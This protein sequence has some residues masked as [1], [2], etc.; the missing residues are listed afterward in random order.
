M[1][2][3]ATN[4]QFNTITGIEGIL[5]VVV[6][7]FGKKTKSFLTASDFLSEGRKKFKNGA[8]IEVFSSVDGFPRLLAIRLTH[9][10]DAVSG[11][12][13]ITELGIKHDNL[14]DE[15]QVTVLLKTSEISARVIA[16]IQ[17]TRPSF[18]DTLIKNCNPSNGTL[19]LRE[20]TLD[21]K[22]AIPFKDSIDDQSRD[23]PFVIISP[24]TNGT[25]LVD[26][27]KLRSLLYGICEL[28][29][30]PSTSNTYEIAGIIG[31]DNAAWRGA[32]NLIMPRRR[33]SGIALHDTLRLMPDDLNNTQG[34]PE[35]EVFLAI[36]HRTNL[37]LSW[38]HISPEFVRQQTLRREINKT[39]IKLK[40]NKDC[41]DCDY[42]TLLEGADQEI[43]VKNKEV[44]GLSEDLYEK[45]GVIRGLEAKIDG[46]TAA[47]NGKQSAASQTPASEG[48]LLLR[49][50]I[51]RREADGACVED[52][53]KI[54]SFLFSDRIV[55]LDSAFTSAKKTKGFKYSEKAH[56]LLWNLATTYWATM[57]AGEGDSEARKIFG[58]SFAAQEKETLS[59]DG[60][61]RR[62][63]LYQGEQL[64]MERHLKIGVKESDAETLRIHFEWDSDD[65]KVIIGHCGPHIPF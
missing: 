29:V 39:L 5:S 25:Y 21:E 35:G 40:N 8:T 53:L 37:P 46:L 30:I 17:V 3:Y 60:K 20:K 4:L 62:T 51:G 58:N 47:L 13:W 15:I 48:I 32:I 23:Y 12:Q 38:R 50:A 16:P 57:Q 22:S 1:I 6:P 24:A 42:I 19:G 56:E 34:T 55:V 61:K 64:L 65:Q 45:I 11:R 41:K 14:A 36:T 18:V 27:P 28:V 54:I 59:S 43:A 33:L 31:R 9:S 7:W 2:I 44:A 10:D 26:I 52:S 49:E 63:F